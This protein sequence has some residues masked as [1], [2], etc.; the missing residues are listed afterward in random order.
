MVLLMLLQ[1]LLPRSVRFLLVKEVK[2]SPGPN[3]WLPSLPLGT[4]APGPQDSCEGFLQIWGGRL[5]FS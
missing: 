4:E 1:E 5:V 3:R 2:S